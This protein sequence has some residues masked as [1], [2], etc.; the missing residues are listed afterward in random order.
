[1]V[2][3]R[4][5]VIGASNSARFWLSAFCIALMPTSIG[6]QD[7]AAL[8]AHRPGASAGWGEHLIAS[9][10]GTIERATFS[11]YAS[12]RNGHAGAA[13]FSERQFRSALARRLCVEDRRADDR[14]AG[15]PDRISDGQSHAQR[16]PATRKPRRPRSIRKACR[17]CSRSSA[18]DAGSDATRSA[19]RGAAPANA[20]THAEDKDAAPPPRSS[21]PLAAADAANVVQMDTANAASANAASASQAASIA[22]ADPADPA[23]SVLTPAGSRMDEPAIPSRSAPCAG[24]SQQRARRRR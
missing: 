5:R 7:L 10:F 23:T 2:A 18:G 22:A 19:D 15:A 4:V 17:N 3:S 6:Y 24:R 9:P 1:M 11:Y 20:E 13:R 16:R 8:I 12:D 21:M 14:A